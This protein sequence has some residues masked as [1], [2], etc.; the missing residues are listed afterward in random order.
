L[1]EIPVSG[2]KDSHV[3][4]LHMKESL[5]MHPLCVSVM[6]QVET[7]MGA[8]NIANLQR[9]FGVDVIFLRA[10]PEIERRMTRH[11]LLRNA[12]PNW[13][14][15]K[16]I[17]TW[18]LNLAHALSIPL[19][20]MGENHDY[21]SGGKD[22]ALGPDAWRQMAHS[23]GTDVRIEDWRSAGVTQADLNPYK[24]LAA[25]QS[26]EVIWLGY[27][28][29]WDSHA[30]YRLAAENGFSPLDETPRGLI[31]N[32]HGIDDLI[33][34]VNAWL[35]FIKFGFARVSDVAFNHI[36]YGR[37]TR[38]EA[39]RL[40]NEREGDLDPRHKSAWLA[41]TDIDERTFD[42]VVARFAN[43]DIVRFSDGR[44]RLLEPAR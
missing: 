7:P 12:W 29:N 33:V 30:I 13:A 43:R 27:Y 3:Q 10:N 15:D 20:V 1:Y 24:G 16:L 25:Q 26:L 22:L 34:P 36:N 8:A 17:Y 39:I 35:K 19:V 44:W 9:R 6:A 41:Y 23:L 2:G 28:I 32:Y 31:D 18:P 38:Q 11:G 14:H 4:V 42:E 21:E 37:M 5:G 40:V